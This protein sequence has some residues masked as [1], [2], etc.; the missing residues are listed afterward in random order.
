MP[1]PFTCPGHAEDV[2][3]HHGILEKG[4]VFLPKPFTAAVLRE[5]VAGVMGH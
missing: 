2:I 1:V 4:T 5:K 3:A